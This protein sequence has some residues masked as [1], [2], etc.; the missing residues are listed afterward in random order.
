MTG[1]PRIMVTLPTPHHASVRIATVL[2]EE[3]L[4]GDFVVPLAVSQRFRASRLG[5]ISNPVLDA[6]WTYPAPAV[7]GARV[8]EAVTAA[9]FRFLSGK[10]PIR[11]VKG[12]VPWRA[13]ALDRSAARRIEKGEHD[14]VVVLATRTPR[15]EMVARRNNV[16]V[17]HQ[18]NWDSWGVEEQLLDLAA[19]AKTEAERADILRELIPGNAV[20][21]TESVSRATC[22]ITESSR[23]ARRVEP[24]V[25]PG[26]PI[27]ALGQ[28]VDADFFTPSKARAGASYLLSVSPSYPVGYAKCVHT[29]NEA[30][31]LAGPVVSRCRVAGWDANLVPGWSAHRNASPSKGSQHFA[32]ARSAATVRRV[33]APD[34]G[35]FHAAPRPRT[36]GLPAAPPPPA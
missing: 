21:A 4:L 7:S 34:G 12:L 27:F 15:T 36:P 26:T 20:R 32:G 23:M 11:G 2:H 25:S 3:G 33:R 6:R 17:I 28:G 9:A 24:L 19:N 22:V 10:G 1:A 8:R 29:L 16:P 18:A 31:R 13:R 35:R 30:I 5:R 14:A